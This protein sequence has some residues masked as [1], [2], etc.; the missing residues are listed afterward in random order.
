MTSESRAILHINILSFVRGEETLIGPIRSPYEDEVVAMMAA[1]GAESRYEMVSIVGSIRLNNKDSDQREEMFEMTD[2][3]SFSSPSNL[4]LCT[5][6][7]DLIMYVVAVSTALPLRTVRNILT[8]AS[9][10]CSERAVINK[11]GKKA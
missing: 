3:L 9:R 6:Y 7:A 10:S 4:L 8:A 2:G 11:A 5:R 1:H